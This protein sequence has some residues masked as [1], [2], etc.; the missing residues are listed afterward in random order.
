MNKKLRFILALH[1]L[2]KLCEEYEK[3]SGMPFLQ[4]SINGR[5]LGTPTN[6]RMIYNRILGK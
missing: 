4:V 2:L 5:S 1:N 6:A 3:Q